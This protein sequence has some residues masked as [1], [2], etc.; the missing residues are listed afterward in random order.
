MSETQAPQSSA[1]RE[2]RP[3][4]AVNRNTA[5]L[6]DDQRTELRWLH[7]HGDERDLTNKQLGELIGYSESTISRLYGSDLKYAGNLD[8]VC[9][10]IRK[11][12]LAQEAERAAGKGDRAPFIE[13]N[14]S[15][16]VWKLCTAAQEYRRMVFAYGESQIGKSR[17]LKEFAERHK[18]DVVY[19]EMPVGGA[20]ANFLANGAEALRFSARAKTRELRR[21]II[22]AFDGRMLLI[23]DQ[24][25]R[26]FS[27]SHGRALDKLSRAQLATLDFLIE[28]FDAKEP[29][30]ALFGT[31]VFRDGLKGFENAN[32]FKQL[33]R[34]GLNTDG[35]QLPDIPS[36]ADLNTFAK[37][38]GL[39]PATG[40][41][42]ELQ[43]TIISQDG[44]GLW[45]TRLVSAKR[46]AAKLGRRVEWSDVIRAHDF[47]TKVARYEN[48]EE[49]A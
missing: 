43:S 10:A 7:C 45:I 8:E 3:G 18:G 2:R 21:R 28:V 41:A 23:V 27:D 31:N 1:R 24:L 34:R 5:N 12:R 19:W 35:F 30:M 25:H 16:H 32:F 49:A 6:P 15:R 4:D 46:R 22:D 20:L 36:R 42:L 40:D 11:V 37:H 14:L 9:D 17:S 44:L 38:Y 39:A 26:A 13:T 29:G 47:F 48:Q 33:R